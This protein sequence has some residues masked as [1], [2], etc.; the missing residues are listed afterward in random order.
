MADAR[1]VVLCCALLAAVLLA[2]GC[3]DRRQTAIPPDSPA[4][5][6]AAIPGVWL[7]RHK[8]RL[9]LPEHGFSQSFDGVMR[10][11]ADTREIR[12]SAL[13]GL[14]LQLFAMEIGPDS[15]RVVYLHPSLRKIPHVTGHIASSIRRIWFDCSGGMPHTMAEQGGGWEIAVSGGLPDVPWPRDVR[16]VDSRAG[17]TVSVRLVLAEREDTP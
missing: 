5:G 8:V 17:Y 7:F 10:L 9:E 4:S 14:G 15:M 13:G 16:L 11:D 1:R 6:Q 2:G 12:V 3:A